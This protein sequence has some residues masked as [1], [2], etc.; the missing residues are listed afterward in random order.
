[1]GKRKKV[2]ALSVGILAVIVILLILVWTKHGQTPKAYESTGYAMGT[3]VQ[4]TVYGKNGEAAAAAASKSVKE[5]ENLISWRINTSDIARLNKAAGNGQVSVD[6]KTS[7]LLQVSL[8][9][10]KES[11]GAFDPTI[12]PVSS[13]WNF[14]GDKQNLPQK[15]TLEKALTCV[16]Y[17]NLKVNTSGLAA[18]LKVSG[19]GVD[20][21]GIGKG[22]ACDEAVAAY[23]SAGAEYGIIAVGGSVGMYGVKS[24]KTPWHVAVR[25]PGSTDD[26]SDAMGQ[27]DMSSGFVSTSGSYE[28]FFVKDGKTYHH[29]LNP[30]TGYPE[31]NGL[32]SVTITADSGALSDALSTACFIL[33]RE[34]GEALLKKY[35][36]GGIFIDTSNKVYVTDNLKSSFKISNNNYTLNAA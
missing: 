31:N 32:V 27:I 22:S 5:L 23:K 13:Q 11:G 10:A 4:Q 19:M 25:N 21:G 8:D 20:L 24:D 18:N 17:N 3:Y 16:G 34:K 9:V 26:S 12:L 33:G 35:N 30:K 28:K 29:L 15:S 14:D 1:M 36:A 7:A 6:S 2:I